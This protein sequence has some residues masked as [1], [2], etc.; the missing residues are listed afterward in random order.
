[1]ALRDHQLAGYSRIFL[2]E[3]KARPSLTPAYE[4]LMRAGALSWGQGDVTLIRKPD[5]DRYGK[6]LVVGKV[7]GEEGNPEITI[8]ARYTTDLSRFFKLARQI[9]RASCRETG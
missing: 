5:P 4:G 7:V 9:G 1:M 2:T 3:G 8:T 6:F